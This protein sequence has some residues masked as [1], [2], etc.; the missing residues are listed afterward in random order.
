MSDDSDSTLSL[1]DAEA[2]GAEDSEEG[3]VMSLEEAQAPATMQAATE[4]TGPPGD[5]KG[6]TDNMKATDIKDATDRK[7]AIDSKMG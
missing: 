6:A 7:T 3:S 5:S 1:E 2:S 4:A